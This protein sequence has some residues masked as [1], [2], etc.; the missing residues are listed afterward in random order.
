[1][2]NK[3]IKKTLTVFIVCIF[4]FSG[5]YVVSSTDTYD[6]NPKINIPPDYIT[7][8]AEDG[9][10]S[11]FDTY[12]SNVPLGYNISSGRYP[13]WCVQRS[14]M[15]DRGVFHTVVLYSSYDPEMPE[16]FQDEDWDKV[17]YLLN[18]KQ[19]NTTDIQE[20]IWYF[21]GD[22]PPSSDLAEQMILDA[23]AN[24]TGFCPK[25]GDKI[26]ILIDNGEDLNHSIQ[27]TIIEVTIPTGEYQGC[28]LRFWTTHLDYWQKYHPFQRIRNV[29]DIPND[30]PHATIFSFLFIY[31]V[32]YFGEGHSIF[33]AA[34]T[35]LKHAVV[36]LLNA[37]HPE[38]NYPLT[39]T[40]IIDSVNNAFADLNR[41]TMLSL[42]DTLEHYNNF[43]TNI[44]L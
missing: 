2:G 21:I 27:R 34:N 5:T 43:S 16:S 24:G 15:M 12:L 30:L 1:M 28:N 25:P 33:G 13:G 22:N 38:V 35:L 14:V 31:I 6:C 7:M 10:N 23:E 32:L 3:M 36:A 40:E 29:F 20:S 9:K 42:K 4:I 11:H 44:N 37:A 26:A 19:G 41:E 17:N 8:V 39:E 18:N